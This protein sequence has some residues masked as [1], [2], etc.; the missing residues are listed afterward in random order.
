MIRAAH[1]GKADIG[2]LSHIGDSPLIIT[3]I[4]V[5]GGE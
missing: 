1:Y 5:K 3:D 4:I 2:V